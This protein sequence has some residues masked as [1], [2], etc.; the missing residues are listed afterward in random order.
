MPK[1]KYCIIISFSFD[2]LE[3][4]D[5]LQIELYHQKKLCLPISYPDR[6]YD[7]DSFDCD[8]NNQNRLSHGDCSHGWRKWSA[9]ILRKAFF[10]LLAELKGNRIIRKNKANYSANLS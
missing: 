9:Y 7:P 10:H 6:Q 3:T 5:L 8:S 4:I 2:Y 1:I